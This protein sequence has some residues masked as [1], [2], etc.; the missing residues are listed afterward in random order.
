M[1]TVKFW[2]RPVDGLITKTFNDSQLAEFF[3]W[4]NYLDTNGFKYEHSNNHRQ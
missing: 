3:W 1:H 4:L 2:G